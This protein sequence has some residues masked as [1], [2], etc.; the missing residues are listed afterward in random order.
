MILAF[1]N[2]VEYNEKINFIYDFVSNSLKNNINIIILLF[3]EIGA[4]KTF[5]CKKLLER[6]NLL[7]VRSNTYTYYKSY[8]YK[9]KKIMHADFFK[10]KTQYESY[11]VL[12]EEIDNHNLILA[13]W[14]NFNIFENMWLNFQFIKIKILR[15]EKSKGSLEIKFNANI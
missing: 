14:P 4:G 13:E 6:F 3:G 7:D 15:T 1:N 12:E 2:F 9:N 8:T 11:D 5:F 10:I